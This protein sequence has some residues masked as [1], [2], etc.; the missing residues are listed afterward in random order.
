MSTILVTGGAGFIGSHIV[1]GLIAR[2]DAV[3]VLDD[4]STGRRE[5]IEESLDRATLTE[6]DV[7][8]EATLRRCVAGCQYVFHEAALPSVMRSV[9][10]PRLSHD[11]NVNGTL[12]LLIACR[13]LGVKRVVIASSSSVY[14]EAPGFPRRETQSLWPMSP[15]AAGKLAVEAY[16][17]SF[18][19]VYDLG[20]VC[21]RY[22]NIFGPRQNHRSEY[23]IAIPSFVTRMLAGDKP[24][25]YGDGEQSR[26]FTYVENVV[27]ANLLA[28][29]A[30]G[31]SGE[32]FNVGCGERFTLNQIIAMIN[33]LLGT[34]IETEYADPRPGDVRRSQADVGKARN[35]LGYEP[36]VAF[37]EGLR[38]TIDWYRKT[39]TQP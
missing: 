18:A 13:E 12:S 17:R 26:D 8:D 36:T 19:Q 35:V 27:R 20:T 3:R 38:R 6:G 34:Q 4:F 24:I 28:L 1:E 21:L 14:G 25:V 33:K 5:N 11:V 22:F 10:D 29:T 39:V 37:E 9:E 32:A 23:A 16:A 7:R 31:A 2:G 30:D 15:Y